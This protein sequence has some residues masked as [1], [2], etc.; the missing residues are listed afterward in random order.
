MTS[1]RLASQLP[2][3]VARDWSLVL[4]AVGVRHELLT[5]ASGAELWIGPEDHARA[6]WEIERYLRENRGQRA[7]PVS[8]PKYRHAL[9]GVASYAVVLISVTVA[10]LYGVGP[11]TGTLR[12]KDPD[13]RLFGLGS[14]RDGHIKVDRMLHLKG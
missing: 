6:A 13:G 14:W 4:H 9:W 11:D 5:T 7:A 1:V 10:A 12:L 2:A 8:W 3:Q